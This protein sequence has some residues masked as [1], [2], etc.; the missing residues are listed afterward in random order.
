ME[1]LTGL[2]SIDATRQLGGRPAHSQSRV[3]IASS[4]CILRK[5]HRDYGYKGWLPGD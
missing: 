4:F 2:T 3:A 5:P 1:A